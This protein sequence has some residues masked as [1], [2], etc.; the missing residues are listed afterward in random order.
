MFLFHLYSFAC[1]RKKASKEQKDLSV[2]QNNFKLVIIKKSF[3]VTY[4]VYCILLI[5]STR[6]IWLYSRYFPKFCALSFTL[7][8]FERKCPPEGVK[9]NWDASLSGSGQVPNVQVN[10]KFIVYSQTQSEGTLA[11]PSGYFYT[12]LNPWFT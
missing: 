8:Q 12:K 7:L 6:Q 4:L 5:S 2:E 3:L 1:S 9:A 10:S 11:A